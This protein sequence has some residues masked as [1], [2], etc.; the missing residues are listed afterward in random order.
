VS[1]VNPILAGLAAAFVALPIVL[2]FLRR[3]RPPVMWGAM[4]FLLEAYR[5][6]RRRLTLEQLLLLA[7]R[8]L[9]VLLVAA[10]VGRPVLG[11]DPAAS[12]P[13]EVYLLLDNS[14]ASGLRANGAA[15]LE[16][17]RSRA[18][19]TL[20]GLDAAAGDRAALV[21]LGGPAE[22]VVL[23]PSGDLA[24]VRRAIESATLTDSRADLVGALA[25]VAESIGSSPDRAR[26]TVL[27]LSTLREGSAEIGRSL[28]AL[29]EGARLVA[30]KP[31]AEPAANTAVT[32]FE[33]VRRVIVGDQASGGQ[34][35]VA[36]AR[37]GAGLDGEHRVDIRLTSGAGGEIGRGEA[38]FPPGQ[39]ETSAVVGF[40]LP[41]G[42][43]SL[44]ITAQITGDAL[45]AD[46]SFAR[47]LPRRRELQVGL[48]APRSIGAEAGP[49]GFAPADWVR[50]ALSPTGEGEIRP[51]DLTPASLDRPRLSPLDA[52]IV[53]DPETLEDAAWMELRGFVDRGGLLVLTP[54]TREGVQLWT[55]RLQ[56]ALGL[57]WTVGREPTR[58][59]P[60]A[61]VAGEDEAEPLL[62]VI[63]AELRS[64]LSGVSVS[65]MLEVDGSATEARTLL[66]TADG[67][68]LLI[69]G[70]PAGDASGP[71]PGLVVY[72]ASALSLEWSDL[73]ARPIMVP[74][75]QEIVRQGVG[76]ARGVASETA[77]M[78]PAG[79]VELVD[80]RG[81][82]AGAP[83]RR[84]GV[85]RSADGPRGV[86]VA[87]NADTAGSRVGVPDRA[88]LEAWLERA[89]GGDG[90]VSWLN[91][92]DGLSGAQAG[93]DPARS[94]VEG[95]AVWLA[96]GALALC[97]IETVAA[98]IVS[99][100]AEAGGVTA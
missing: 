50:L 83:I 79:G 1:L 81:E 15:A 54:S 56:S 26:P 33:P 95:W 25:A 73:P 93:V 30:L 86:T 85:Y 10:M 66:R 32:G 13:S 88:G 24:G 38:V 53:L 12:G 37:S 59:E 57:P 22:S 75:M 68:P 91:E 4:R 74:L 80:A 72:L 71:A 78:V 67:R 39:T 94:G 58:G 97:V 69:A 20:D 23:P 55:D 44:T 76:V 98:R 31:A 17:L 19:V 16:D 35:S 92:P 60:A 100:G 29:P 82:P 14:I 42:E 5:R 90:R 77:G 6:T 70:A 41:P 89:A 65:R 52:M 45:P 21:L 96:A 2:H 11:G 62:G 34:A 63:G 47:P 9:L 64:L 36:L 61:L 87:V 99:R 49:A 84:A 46:D 40:T 8:C 27:V 48:L 43:A 3:R 7:S 18:L 51:V 28:P